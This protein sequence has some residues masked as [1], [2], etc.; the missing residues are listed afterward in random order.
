MV[1]ATG[2]RACGWGPAVRGWASVEGL[3]LFDARSA[4]GWDSAGVG[5]VAFGVGTGLGDAG[6]TRLHQGT[7]WPTPRECF[8]TPLRDPVENGGAA[9]P[10]GQS[11]PC[12][13]Q[14]AQWGASVTPPG[15]TG[16]SACWSSHWFHP[17][18]AVSTGS[19]RPDQVSSHGL[20]VTH[21]TSGQDRGSCVSAPCP[22]WLPGLLVSPPFL[23]RTL[24][25]K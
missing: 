24:S 4:D 9:P 13:L 6:H 3:C 11:V 17:E 12:C 14:A 2:C 5:W 21:V 16:P 22:L 15:G 8:L 18:C 19:P 1:T 25:P 10:C 20:R 7:L 23:L